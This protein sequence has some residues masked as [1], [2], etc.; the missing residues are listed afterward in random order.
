MRVPRVWVI[1]VL[2]L[3]SSLT[4]MGCR[5]SPVG[6]VTPAMGPDTDVGGARLELGL[7]RLEDLRGG[8]IPDLSAL[9]Y[10]SENIKMWGRGNTYSEAYSVHDGRHVVVEEQIRNSATSTWDSVRHEG[11]ASFDIVVAASGGKDA[12]AFAGVDLRGQLVIETWQLEAGSGW[13]EQSSPSHEGKV[14]AKRRVFQG[15]YPSA[16]IAAGY[17]ASHR[18]V[19]LVVDAGGTRQLLQYATEGANAPLLL[20]DSASLPE[21]ANMTMLEDFDH[22]ALGRI[23]VLDESELQ[24]SS[25]IL[26]DANNDG[27]FEDPPLTGTRHELDEQ[28]LGN[29]FDFKPPGGD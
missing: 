25:V 4:A 2:A 1:A 22:V 23:W 29:W 11:E 6:E 26:F 21:L 10:V 12:L 17:D 8:D 20:Y 14:F 16:V 5:T 27:I 15:P 24:Q 13:A 9:G 7:E 18:F 3:L 19:L 28:G